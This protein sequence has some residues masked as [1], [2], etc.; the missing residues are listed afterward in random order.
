MAELNEETLC[1]IEG[2]VRAILGKEND[3]SFQFSNAKGAERENCAVLYKSLAI[4]GITKSTI[5]RRYGLTRQL[6]NYY[7]NKY[8]VKDKDK[9]VMV[10]KGIREVLL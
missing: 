6:Y 8:I 9:L 7:A 1:Q 5:A 4:M 10:L 2:A 3:Y